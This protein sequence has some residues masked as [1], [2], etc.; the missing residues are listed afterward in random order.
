MSASESSDSNKLES[1]IQVR[2]GSSPVAAL[3]FA[4]C[5]VTKKAAACLWFCASPL[6]MSIAL[7]LLWALFFFFCGHFFFIIPV[8]M[9]FY[10]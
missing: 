8:L 10:I 6:R 7:S 1:V 5:D 3:V 2:P 4:A 9:L